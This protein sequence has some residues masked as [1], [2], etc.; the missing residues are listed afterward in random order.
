VS[1]L[2]LDPEGCLLLP[3][4]LRTRLGWRPGERLR[5]T[6]EGGRLVVARAAAPGGDDTLATLRERARQLAEQMR[7]LPAAQKL[8]EIVSGLRAAPPRGEPVG[9]PFGGARPSVPASCYLHPS[10]VLI[11]D[12]TLGEDCSV[13][14]GAVLRGD[15]NAAHQHPGGRGPPR[16]PGRGA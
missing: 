15:V 12:V 14:A 11:G 6:V 5:A 7:Q 2:E 3:S 8:Q 10:A 16:R 9:T 1:E 4:D 13:W